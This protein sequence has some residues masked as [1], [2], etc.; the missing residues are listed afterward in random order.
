LTTETTG[1]P[2]QPTAAELQSAWDAELQ[3]R[4]DPAEAASTEAEPAT[5]EQV[6]AT[7]VDPVEARFAAL[8]AAN[9]RLQTELGR[10]NGRVAQ[11]QSTLDKGAAVARAVK[12]APTT[13]QQEAAIEDPAEW[14]QLMEEFPEWGTAVQK[15][16]D[17]TLKSMKPA[18]PQ[19]APD[20]DAIGQVVDNA[21][22]RNEFARVDRKHPGW[23]DTVKTKEFEDWHNAQPAAIQA[24]AES[25]YSDDAVEMLNLFKASGEKSPAQEVSEVQKR[26]AAALTAAATTNKPRAPTVRTTD[27]ENLGPKDLWAIE[28]ANRQK[29]RQT[30]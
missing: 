2:T 10:A 16:L 11:M 1:Q 21:L 29:R 7:T 24:L 25:D 30:A 3:S 4:L 12:D 6:P 13:E 18:Q 15:K 17:A 27:P 22:A 26:R 8:E 28:K 9:Q 23:R 5:T 19:A 20:N 14:K